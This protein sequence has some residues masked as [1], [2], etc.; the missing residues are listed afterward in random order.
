LWAREGSTV[1][2]IKNI[3]EKLGF[4][5]LSLDELTDSYGLV[6]AVKG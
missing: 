6:T 3:L 1:E 5:I 4:I 2:D